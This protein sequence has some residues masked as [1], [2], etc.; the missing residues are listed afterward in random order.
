MAV[1]CTRQGITITDQLLFDTDVD[2]TAETDYFAGSA[3]LYSIRIEN[4]GALAWVK[5]YDNAAPTVGTTHPDYILQADATTNL[6]WTIVDGF[7]MSYTSG[8][9]TNSAG[10]AG[11]TTPAGP[12]KM[13]AVA[14]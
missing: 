9:A 12:V 13:Y 8:A 11:T 4:S 6:T 5:L 7:A 14:R 10:T 1:S 2:E 3:V